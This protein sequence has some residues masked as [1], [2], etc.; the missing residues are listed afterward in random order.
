MNLLMLI[1][2]TIWFCIIAFYAIFTSA[3]LFFTRVL[4]PCLILIILIENYLICVL[5]GDKRERRIA[6][7]TS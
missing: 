4:Y 3:P 5:V 1:N 7:F 6:N 2:F